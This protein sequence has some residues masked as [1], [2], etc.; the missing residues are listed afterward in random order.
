MWERER[1]VADALA[2]QIAEAEQ[3]LASPASH[4]AGATSFASSGRHVSHTAVLWH[5]PTDPLVT[6]LHY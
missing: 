2:R 3:L 6:Q 5:D 1:D 4:D